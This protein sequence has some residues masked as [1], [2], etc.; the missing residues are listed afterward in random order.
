[1]ARQ[2]IRA[3]GRSMVGARRAGLTLPLRGAARGGIMR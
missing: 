1:M 3:R 2:R